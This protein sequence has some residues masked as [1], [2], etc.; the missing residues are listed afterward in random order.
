MTDSLFDVPFD[1]ELGQ[2]VVEELRTGQLMKQVQEAEQ[3]KEV[4]RQRGEGVRKDGF[5]VELN[6][7]PT[8]YHYWGQRLGYECW[9]DKQFV[10]EFWRDNEVCRVN[11]R[12]AKTVIGW[13]AALGYGQRKRQASNLVGGIYIK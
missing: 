2:A 3:M 10:R 8:S 11:N 6:I 7:P 12:P 9:E 4:A 5:E 13:T 1:S